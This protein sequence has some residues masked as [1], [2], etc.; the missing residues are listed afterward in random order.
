MPLL[1]TFTARITRSGFT[2]ANAIA[3]ARRTS[4]GSSRAD[5]A[6][7]RWSAPASGVA[8]AAASSTSRSGRRCRGSAGPKPI[9][10][11]NGARWPAEG[12]GRKPAPHCR[13]RYRAPSPTNPSARFDMPVAGSINALRLVGIDGDRMQDALRH[14]T[15]CAG[16]RGDS[17]RRDRR[18]GVARSSS[19]GRMCRRCAPFPDDSTVAS[20]P[21]L[22]HRED[23]GG[24]PDGSPI[25]P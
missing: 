6:T 10:G 19:A 4:A 25:L 1:P 3:G 9:S 5:A 22:H 20:R 17:Q 16:L 14:R 11:H 18:Q 7:V 24:R 12:A 2:A 13:R 15:L 21:G 23:A 8:T